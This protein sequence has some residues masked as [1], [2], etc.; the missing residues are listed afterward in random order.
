MCT[1]GLIWVLPYGATGLQDAAFACLL[2]YG[3]KMRRYSQAQFCF[4]RLV[5][6]S[7][8]V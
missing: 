7:Q 8:I 6:H 5:S 2:L 4:F 3:Y 1:L